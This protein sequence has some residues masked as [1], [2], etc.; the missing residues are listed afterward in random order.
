MMLLPAY[1]CNCCRSS[2][3][4]YYKECYYNN[5]Y[6]IW[7]FSR[8]SLGLLDVSLC[9]GSSKVFRQTIVIIIIVIIII[10]YSLQNANV[11]LLND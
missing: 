7:P 8:R 2:Y 6:Y 5:N 9:F 10:I 3:R 11:Q 1:N 4:Y